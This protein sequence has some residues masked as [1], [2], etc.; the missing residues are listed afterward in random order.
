[1]SSPEPQTPG[2]G[3]RAAF[4][5]AAASYDAHFEAGP[6]TPLLRLRV[7]EL[8]RGL[9]PPGS[10]VLE[11]N[12]GTGTDAIALAR[13]GVHVMA[14][15]GA[16]R[17]ISL[18]REKAYAEGLEAMIS[19]QVLPLERLED[20]VGTR[21]DGIFSNLG[22]LNCLADIRP[23]LHPLALLLPPGAPLALGLMGRF[24]LWETASSLASGDVGRALRRLRGSFPARV[25]ER[26]FTVFYHSPGEL[27]RRL[28]DAFVHERTLGL[29]ILTPPPTSDRARRRLG[30]LL[31]LLEEADRLLSGIRPFHALG[32]HYV[33]VF[34]RTA[35]GA[36]A[37]GL[38][39]TA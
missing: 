22:G 27:R 11:L 4:E 26:H 21:F 17:M 28:G 7:H 15:D 14:T 18:V 29:N 39:P 34:R 25:A 5:A 31:P 16:P 33:A 20:L 12:C 10:R 36:S 32:D 13:G 24:C 35:A 9:F 2:R 3:A 8:L 19:T 30:R 37:G 23:L 1:M 38:H 6:G